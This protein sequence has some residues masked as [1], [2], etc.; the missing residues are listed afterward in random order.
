MAVIAKETVINAAPQRVFEYVSD[1]RKHPEW[2]QHGLEV[3]QTSAGPV[4]T[5]ATFSSVAHQFGTQR[6]TQVITEYQPDSR[7]TFEAT[8]SLGVA[9]HSFALAPDG[10]G[11]RVTKSMELIKPSLLARVMGPMIASQQRK[12]LAVDLERIKTYLEGSS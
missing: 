2:A 4:Q 12:A 6:E 8:G 5:G 9:R 7:V 3:T 11:T 10:A 1:L